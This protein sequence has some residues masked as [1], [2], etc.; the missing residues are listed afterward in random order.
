MRLVITDLDNTLYD[1]VTYFAKSFSAM[2]DQL[3]RLLNIDRE[4]ILDQFGSI[5]RAHHNS[6]HPFAVLEIPA[7]KE[8]FAGKTTAHVL[9]FLEPALSAFNEE[10]NKNLKLYQS[11]QSTLKIFRDI[12]IPV[13]GHTESVAANAYFRLRKLDIWQY[14]DHLYAID[15]NL[16]PHP[17]SNRGEYHALPKR[18]VEKLPLSERKPNPQLLLNICARHGVKPDDA[19]YVGDSL[20]RDMSMAKRAG[21]FAVWAQYGTEYNRDLWPILAR[22][23]HWS[24]ADVARETQLKELYRH[25]EPDI[26][27]QSF[28]QL[29]SIHHSSTKGRLSE[30]AS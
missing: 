29:L 17:N 22:V 25:V 12:G 9:E 5:H 7:V 20:A 24:D 3:V 21:I 2:I 1:W 18:T 10:R 27:I 8:Q 15:G 13:V 30:A 6:E 23:T 26:S 16:L 19:L 14:F 4:L 11:V 28:D